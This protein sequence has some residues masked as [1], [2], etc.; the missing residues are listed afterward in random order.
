MSVR[1]ARSTSASGRSHSIV[2]ASSG[3]RLKVGNPWCSKARVRVSAGRL[4]FGLIP[5]CQLT[6]L[7]ELV[8]AESV[9]VGQELMTISL[10]F[11]QVFRHGVERPGKAFLGKVDGDDFHGIQRLINSAR[12]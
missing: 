6:E 11:W 7:I 8:R 3:S 4:S 2:H 9:S 5:G 1:A 10:Q 12:F